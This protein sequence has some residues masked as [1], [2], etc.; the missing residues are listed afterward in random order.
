MVFS[1]KTCMNVRVMDVIVFLVKKTFNVIVLF[2]PFVKT[3][4]LTVQGLQTCSVPIARMSITAVLS[5]VILSSPFPPVPDT[6]NRQQ[7]DWFA[8]DLP[9]RDAWSH[10]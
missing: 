3:A 10:I 8:A 2:K 5:H 4:A 7:C 6:Q 1:V 9:Y